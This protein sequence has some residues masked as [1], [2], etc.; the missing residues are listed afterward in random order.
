MGEQVLLLSRI[1]A[2]KLLANAPQ[3]FN[4]HAVGTS[5]NTSQIVN[6]CKLRELKTQTKL[7]FNNDN[8]NL[9]ATLARVFFWWGRGNFKCVHRSNNL[10]QLASI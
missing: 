3:S 5:L 6:G 4:L 7:L 10:N 1:A 9:K 8:G 2:I